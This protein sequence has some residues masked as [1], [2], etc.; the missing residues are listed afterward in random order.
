LHFV[1]IFLGKKSTEPVFVY[2]LSVIFAML[3]AKG[4]LIKDV[5]RIDYAFWAQGSTIYFIMATSLAAVLVHAIRALYVAAPKAS[6]IRRTQIN[7]L[8]LAISIAF[9]GGIHDFIPIVFGYTKYPFSNVNVYPCGSVAIIIWA[10]VTAYAI[11]KHRLL[12]IEFVVRKSVTYTIITFLL[13]IPCLGLVITAQKFLFG[14]I[15][16]AFTVVI[17]LLFLVIAYAFPRLR[18]GT[19]AAVTKAFFRERYDYTRTLNRLSSAMISILDK[20]QLLKKLVETTATAL[21]SE[22]AS[23]FLWDDETNLYRMEASWGLSKPSHE[24]GSPKT[25]FFMWLEKNKTYILKDELE[26]GASTNPKN[27]IANGFEFLIEHM[28]SMEADLSIPITFRNKLYG[29]LNLGRK[30][31]KGL[32]TH[33]DIDLLTGLANQTA[34]ALENARMYTDLQKSMESMQ[35]ADRLAALGTLA[36]GM[37]HEIRNP[38]V[39]I[40]TFLQLV[41]ERHNDKEFMG[42]FHA[43][44]S[45]EA[46]RISNL[47]GQLLSF[48]RPAPAKFE[49]KYMAE[50]IDSLLPL[51][52]NRARK[53]GITLKKMYSENLPLINVDA[54][55]MKQVFLNI[56]LNALDATNSGGEITIATRYIVR[57]DGIAYVQ[58]QISDTGEGISKEKLKKLFTPFFTTKAQGTGLAISHRIIEEHQGTISVESREGQGTTFYINLPVAF[59]PPQITSSHPEKI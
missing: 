51:I 31:K 26:S 58:I 40:K 16:R 11:V 59:M 18:P 55:Q 52:D 8:I 9:A 56:L 14:H 33:E 12:D 57:E 23:I 53:K 38:L 54:D 32:Y 35:R 41:P 19:E 21:K 17:F 50:I 24:V 37:A 46:D 47:V 29:V 3:N 13:L 1:F 20:K 28:N 39:S 42:E 25:S 2:F 7:Y 22:N 15:N 36:A 48:A 5:I 10:S 49:E 30:K 44:A 45:S 27:F 6:G 43:L 4:F 34:I